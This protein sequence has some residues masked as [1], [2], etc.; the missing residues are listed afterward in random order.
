MHLSIVTTSMHLEVPPA[1]LMPVTTSPPPA[2][3]AT[4]RAITVPV[5]HPPPRV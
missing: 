1:L 4:L 5:E 2:T 3:V